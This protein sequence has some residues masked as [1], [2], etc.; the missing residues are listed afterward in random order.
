MKSL[1]LVPDLLVPK[2]DSNQQKEV[3]KLFDENGFVNWLAVLLLNMSLRALLKSN[4][5]NK[6]TAAFR[7]V[8]NTQSVLSHEV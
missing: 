5:I 8:Q 6:I 1:C 3:A 7:R 2:L 4:E